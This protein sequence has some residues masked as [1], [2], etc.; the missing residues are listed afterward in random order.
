MTLVFDKSSRIWSKPNHVFDKSSRKV[1]Q[2]E[3]I[4]IGS[5]SNQYSDSSNMTYQ[6]EPI[7]KRSTTNQHMLERVDER[8]NCVVCYKNLSTQYGRQRARN[9]GRKSM[10]RCN[11]CEKCFCKDCFKTTHEFLS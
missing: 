2:E 8:R 6:E 3:P 9:T 4:S 1:Y 10:F 7:S 5:K 11:I